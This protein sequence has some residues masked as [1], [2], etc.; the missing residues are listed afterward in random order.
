MFPDDV[1][2]LRHMH[3][4]AKEALTFV[5]GKQRDKLNED[6]QLALALLKCIEIIGE[7]ASKVTVET[8]DQHPAI[9]WAPI[10]GMRNRLIHGYFEIDLDLVWDTIQTDL[11]PLVVGL[12]KVLASD[13]AN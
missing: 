12:A 8:R 11:P 7:A 13:P 3:D 4:A 2:R 5:Q 9:P 1:T 6:R 10:V